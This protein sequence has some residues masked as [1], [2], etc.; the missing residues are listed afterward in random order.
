MPPHLD[1]AKT[2]THADMILSSRKSPRI[3]LRPAPFTPLDKGPLSSTSSRFN[4]NHLI[5][6][7]P[8]SPGLPALVPRHGKPVP[9]HTPRRCLRAAIWLAG[10]V[11]IIYYGF[12]RLTLDHGVKPVGWATHSGDQYEMVGESELPDFPTPVVVTDGRGRAKWTVSIPPDH[13]FPL[14]PKQYAEICTQNME[15]S[16][17]V[18]DLHAHIHHQHA[19][20]YDYYHVD[21]HFMDVAEAEAH[22]L[23]PGPKAKTSMKE[24]GSLIGENKDGLIESAV[25]EKTMTFLLETHDAGL[26]KMLMMMWTAY[27]LAKKEGRDFFIDDSRWVY[28]KYTNFFRPPPIPTCRPPPRHEMLPCP[29]HARHLIVSAVTAASTFGGAFNEAFE[30]PRKME[31]Y[32]QKPIFDLARQGY[33]ALFRLN[34]ADQKYVDERSDELLNKTFGPP[35]QEDQKGIIIG[36]HVRHGDRHPYEFQY[37]DSYMPLD[38]YA[39][40][41]QE[42]LHKAFNDSGEENDMALARSLMVVAS[43]DPEVYESEEFSRSPRAQEQIRLAS[44]KVLTSTPPPSGVAAIRKFVEESVGWEGGFFAGMF[45]SLGK[46]TSVPATAVEAPDTKLPPTEEALRL[47]ELVGRAYLMDLAVLGRASDRIVCTVSSMGCKVLAVMMG[48]ESAV[49]DGRW[50]NIDG[51]FEW[52]GVSW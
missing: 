13:E 8:P 50:V 31:V 37:R 45:W 42:L 11:V 18:A 14:E 10:V 22:G 51:D 4:F 7:P 15:V 30:D 25:C 40:K 27:G 32:R 28:G 38:R 5:V 1:L 36:I 34:E 46:P 35:P 39:E 6:S 19:A 41:A 9:K 52:R 44:N 21:P 48:W 20:H 47:R 3:S 24:D 29:H 33:N 23:L 26:G 2:Y 43:D 12:S 17:H 49:V 16:N